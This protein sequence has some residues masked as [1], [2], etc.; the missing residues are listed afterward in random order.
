MAMEL[1]GRYF[2]ERVMWYKNSWLP[3]RAVVQKA[4]E[5][6]F[7]VNIIII[8]ITVEIFTRKKFTWAHP[9]GVARIFIRGVLSSNS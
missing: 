8:T 6:R 5:T 2:N 9:R 3:A 7:Q 4:L 1:V